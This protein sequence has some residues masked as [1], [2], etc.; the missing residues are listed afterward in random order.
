LDEAGKMG[1]GLLSY[2]LRMSILEAQSIAS[3]PC[4]RIEPPG[5][6]Y[7]LSY[8]GDRLGDVDDTSS[9]YRH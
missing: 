9:E 6:K 5:K 4:A 3:A 7:S 8:E 1:F 2:L